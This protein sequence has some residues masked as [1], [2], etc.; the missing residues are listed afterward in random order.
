LLLGGASLGAQFCLLSDLATT[1]HD[2]AA[3]RVIRA[4]D[5]LFGNDESFVGSNSAL[6]NVQTSCEQEYRN[7]VSEAA[8]SSHKVTV[9]GHQNANDTTTGTPH[10]EVPHRLDGLDRAY[11]SGCLSLHML[12]NE[13]ILTC[14]D[15]LARPS[16]Q[17]PQKFCHVTN[18]CRNSTTDNC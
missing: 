16:K 18:T 9:I 1:T 13:T 2:T 3:V 7:L 11:I 4:A 15:Y 5:T 10:H 17:H 8:R 14:A 6:T 12:I